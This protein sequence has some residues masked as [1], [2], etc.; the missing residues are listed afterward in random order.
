MT[1][2][3]SK[4]VS[5]T[6]PDPA[7]LMLICELTQIILNVYPRTALKQSLL[8]FELSVKSPLE[9]CRN[10]RRAQAGT[11]QSRRNREQ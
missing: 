4:Q 9:Q 2:K 10:Y 6:F 1:E 5:L 3:P 8:S 11:H 7:L